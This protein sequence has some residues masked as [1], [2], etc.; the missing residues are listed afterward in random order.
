MHLL[1]QIFMENASSDRYASSTR[2]WSVNMSGKNLWI[3][4][5]GL[6]KNL[7]FKQNAES[8]KEA[9]CSRKWRDE[10]WGRWGGKLGNEARPI[11]FRRG[12][13]LKTW[14][15]EEGL[16]GAMSGGIASQAAGIA[17]CSEVGL[18]LPYCKCMDQ[19]NWLE[20]GRDGVKKEVGGLSQWGFVLLVRTPAFTL[21]EIGSYL[22]NVS[23]RWH[24]IYTLKYIVSI[25]HYIL[26]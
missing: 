20:W 9:K 16:S 24:Q 3:L 6:I 11:L 23:E 2:E 12:L 18:C 25:F 13:N 1:L 7:D 22:M 26:F 5:R 14:C 19:L 8:A 10:V 17:M 15:K 21:N 4:V